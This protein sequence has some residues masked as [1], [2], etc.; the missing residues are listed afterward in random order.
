MSQ[1][2][3]KVFPHQF[4]PKLMVDQNRELVGA[5]PAN[6]MS[7]LRNVALSMG[8]EVLVQLQFSFGLYGLPRISGKVSYALGMRCER[9]LDEVKFVLEPTIQVLLKSENESVAKE[10]EEHE[11]YEYSDNNLEL[12]NLI[13][14]E[15]LLVL[16]LAPKHQDISLCNQDMVAWLALNK[17]PAQKVDNPFAI[18][19]R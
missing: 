12:A 19:K 3:K 1:F 8:P 13:E 18:L 4:D 5:L 10:S 11:F 6:G 16:P 7:R 9:C 15:L 17:E 2:E 14:D